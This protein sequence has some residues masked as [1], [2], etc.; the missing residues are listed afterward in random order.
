MRFYREHGFKA[1]LTK[2]KQYSGL[3]VKKWYATSIRKERFP[4]EIIY[5]QFPS[6]K[7]IA[8][9]K[10]EGNQKRLN[11]VV[12]DL[13]NHLS[14]LITA[15]LFSNKHEHSLRIISRTSECSPHQLKQF[16]AHHGCPRPLKIEFFSDCSRSSRLEIA[17]DEIFLTTSPCTSESVQSLNPKRHLPFAKLPIDPAFSF[18][19]PLGRRKYKFLL[20]SKDFFYQG[21]ELMEEAFL[22]GILSPDEW[23][24]HLTG[25]KVPPVIFTNGIKPKYHQKI[26]FSLIQEI[27][28]LLSHND[29]YKPYEIVS[30]GGIALTNHTIKPDPS[31]ILE[32]TPSIQGLEK[33][34]SLVKNRPPHFTHEWKNCFKE[35]LAALEAHVFQ[36]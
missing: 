35:T 6:R 2:I 26:P 22:Q 8:Y 10:T 27:D 11:L 3:W 5:A 20:S 23:E 14:P 29:P 9:I 19:Q 28:L 31:I 4:Q 12:D 33:A 36:T 13:E 34:V 15:L 17:E 21:L 7:P 18:K 24:L 25:T 32:E 30:L 1:L 16:L